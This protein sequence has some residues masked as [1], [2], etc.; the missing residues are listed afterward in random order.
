MY[1]HHK[2]TFPVFDFDL[3]LTI[4]GAKEIHVPIYFPGFS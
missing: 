2:G 3:F 4:T 1:V